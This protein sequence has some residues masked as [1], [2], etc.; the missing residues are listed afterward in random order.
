MHRLVCVCVEPVYHRQELNVD[1][2]TRRVTQRRFSPP[3]M[4]KVGQGRERDSGVN[5]YAGRSPPG[6]S[7]FQG[8]RRG[9]GWERWGREGRVT[10]TCS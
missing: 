3:I 7:V 9:W 10:R 5:R 4:W 6:G 8:M 1:A 2:E